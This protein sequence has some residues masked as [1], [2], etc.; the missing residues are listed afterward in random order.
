MQAATPFFLPVVTDGAAFAPSPAAT[1]PPLAASLEQATERAAI[2]AQVQAQAQ[3]QVRGQPPA[4]GLARIPGAQ[5][6]V[7]ARL[8]PPYIHIA[9]FKRA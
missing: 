2:A 9:S 5:G 4:Q 3:A 8:H 1:P 7:L 6:G